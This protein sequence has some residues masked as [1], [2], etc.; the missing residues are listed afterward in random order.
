MSRFDR[1]IRSGLALTTLI[2]SNA[3]ADTEWY[4]P[5]Q[6]DRALAPVADPEQKQ[7]TKPV[8]RA[9]L[10][11]SSLSS[12]MEDDFGIATETSVGETTFRAR[13]EQGWTSL[14]GGIV[15]LGDLTLLEFGG[16]VHTGGIVLKDMG[17]DG[18]I[19]L[20][21]PAAGLRIVGNFGDD[22]PTLFGIKA[23]LAGLRYCRCT[24]SR[25]LTVDFR[26][27]VFDALLGSQEVPD[28]SDP[29]YT[30]S[31]DI[32]LTGWGAAFSVGMAF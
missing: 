9:E 11:I 14:H 30:M 20:M 32:R 2:V 15:S 7:K 16:E 4:Q 8:V 18:K 19:S 22:A 21:T 1:V 6:A 28:P 17:P 29:T 12:E 27:P 13:I 24:S 23:S 5:Q 26:G 10:A 3:A 25:P 31:Q